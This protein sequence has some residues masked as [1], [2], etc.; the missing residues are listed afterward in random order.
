M[1]RTAAP[2]PIG[3]HYFKVG[4]LIGYIRELFARDPILSDVWVAGE[5]A[6]L[7]RSAAGHWYFTLRDG[8]GRIGAVM[9]RSAAV[10]QRAALAEGYSALVHGTIEIYGQRSVY[11]LVAD[12]VLPG[13]AGKLQA[14][15]EALRL[16]L[17]REGLFAPERK[18]PLP[19]YPKRVGLVASETGAALRDMLHVWERRY[20]LLELLLASTPVQGDE[21][22]LGVVGAL[23][24]LAT[25]H[26]EQQPLD[27]IVVARGGGSPEELAV[28]NDERIARAIFACPVPVVSAIGHETDWSIADMVADLRAAT[29]SAA[30]EMVAPEA[31][32]LREQ[33][34]QW[35][36]RVRL[37]TRR[38]LVDRRS[39]VEGYAQQLGR[40][41]PSAQVGETRRR[42]DDLA[43]RATRAVERRRDSARAG[44]ET[45]RLRLGALNPQAT[46]ERGY[47]ICTRDSDGSLVT[48]QG[49]V[50]VTDRVSVR[51]ARGGIVGEVVAKQQAITQTQDAI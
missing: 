31:A 4:E 42:I 51:L 18:R 43:G 33:V 29:P 32:A 45:C 19:I 38:R 26:G 35:A 13:D 6:D 39:A 8:E 36:D 27:L 48:D 5:M 37:A 50:E 40:R 7:T 46:L 3:A 47:A 15:F 9:F 20:P 25:Y 44:L 17:D 34:Q 49:Q 10:R 24:R 2:G 30:A 22:V 11:Q 14:Q 1:A 28:F 21:A 12:L 23:E 16:R 41:S